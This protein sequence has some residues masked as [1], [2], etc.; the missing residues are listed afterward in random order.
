MTDLMTLVLARLTT[1]VAGEVFDNP[2][3][4]PAT[5]ALSLE[6]GFLPPKRS[7]TSEADDINFVVARIMRGK[8]SQKQGGII[9]RLIG[10][11][12]TNGDK[13]DGQEDIERLLDLL[14]GMLDQRT[15]TPYSLDAEAEWF[16]GDPEEGVQPH[17][18]YYVTVDLTFKRQPTATKRR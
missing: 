7:G 16:F 17:P 9:V 11:I 4:P 15:Y 12:H 2:V 14:L 3:S 10:G 1:L 8:E 6:S 5:M 18:K 13:D